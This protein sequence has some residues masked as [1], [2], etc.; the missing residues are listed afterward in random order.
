MT[1]MYKAYF[2]MTTTPFTNEIPVSEL[3]E[4]VQFK[5]LISRLKYLVE[6]KGIGLVT[7]EVGS[8][9]TVSLRAFTS[10][11]H[12]SLYKTIYLSYTTGSRLDLLTSL[13]EH[14]GLIPAYARAKLISQIKQ[15]VER[16]VESKKIY[17][18]LVVDEAHLLRMEAMEELRLLTNYHMDSKNY[19]ILILVGQTELRRKLSLNVNEPLNQRIIVKYHLDGLSR[20][21]LQDYLNHQL[22][23]AGVSAPLFSEPALEAIYQ[24]SKGVMRKVNLFAQASL[25]AC[26]SKKTQIVDADHVR[27]AISDLS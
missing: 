24:A 22:K 7:G 23:R 16:L 14:L 3:F 6:T 27:E 15:D 18:F 4:G 5:E 12:P 20:K 21:E 8:G 25:I 2:G 19:L 11:L 9:K 10:S 13:A 1:N 17:P 26:V